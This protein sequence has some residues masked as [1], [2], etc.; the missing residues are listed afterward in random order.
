[1]TGSNVVHELLSQGLE[2]CLHKSM[3]RSYP[4]MVRT[5]TQHFL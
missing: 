5:N 1:M 4:N 3:Y 2:M